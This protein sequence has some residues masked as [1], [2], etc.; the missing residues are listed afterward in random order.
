[1]KAQCKQSHSL[2]MLVDTKIE[3]SPSWKPAHPQKLQMLIFKLFK[4]VSE[5]Y[6]LA[7]GLRPILR[8]GNCKNFSTWKLLLAK[9]FGPIFEGRGEVGQE[10]LP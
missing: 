5:F 6:S 10:T 4:F 3:T 1:M 2:E 8:R 7:E 9:G